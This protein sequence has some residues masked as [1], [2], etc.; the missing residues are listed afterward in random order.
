MKEYVN[1]ASKIRVL[2]LPIN[3]F[4]LSI[5]I[6]RWIT[7]NGEDVIDLIVMSI[8]FILICSLYDFMF[9]YLK[10]LMHI[11]KFDDEKIVQKYIFSEKKVFYKDIKTI[12]LVGTTIVLSD[13]VVDISKLSKKGNILRKH[14]N[15]NV[16]FYLGNDDSILIAIANSSNCNLYIL[17]STK[18]SKIRIERYFNVV[19]K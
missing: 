4:F 7:F 18:G 3:I 14:F 17:N 19:N 12:L 1:N 13:S 11:T 2:I 10:S 16:M 15:N 8:T 6:I 9:I 5:T